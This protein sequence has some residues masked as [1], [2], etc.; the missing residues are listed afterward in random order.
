MLHRSSTVSSIRTG[1]VLFA[2][3]TR[4]RLRHRY[5]KN[6]LSSALEITLCRYHG[7]PYWTNTITRVYFVARVSSPITLIL[8]KLISGELTVPQPLWAYPRTSARGTSLADAM[9]LPNFH[10]LNDTFQMHELA[11]LKLRMKSCHISDGR[12]PF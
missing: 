4:R 5:R 3:T 9:G 11:F 2:S 12:R 10:P 7:P 8:Q 1:C 6:S